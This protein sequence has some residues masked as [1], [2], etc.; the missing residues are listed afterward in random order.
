[1]LT[2]VSQ[3]RPCKLFEAGYVE[4]KAKATRQDASSVL[5]SVSARSRQA[6]SGTKRA[7]TDGLSLTVPRGES[8]QV[9]P[10]RH[11]RDPVWGVIPVLPCGEI[12]LSS[13]LCGFS[14]PDLPCGPHNPQGRLLVSSYDISWF[15]RWTE[16]LPAV[17]DGVSTPLGDR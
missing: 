12:H 17:N 1:M 6:G 9:T 15:D 5:P 13:S 16:F 4:E 14:S 8:G 2:R 3:P 10:L 7:R 11:W